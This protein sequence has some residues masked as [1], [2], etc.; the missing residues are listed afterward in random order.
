MPRAIMRDGVI[1][2]IERVPPEWADGRELWVEEAR[3]ETPEEIDKLFEELN[4]L[5]AQNDP[6]DDKRLAEAIAEVRRQAK[7][8]PPRMAE[9]PK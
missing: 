2:P 4:A 6:E 3:P 7:G 9:A 1:Y 5:C 8:L